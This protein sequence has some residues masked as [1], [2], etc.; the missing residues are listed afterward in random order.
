MV[1]SADGSHLVVVFIGGLKAVEHQRVEGRILA[2]AEMGA[3]AGDAHV[4][5]GGLLGN[6][7]AKGYAV[8]ERSYLHG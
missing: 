7:V 5:D 6:E 4:A 8:I 1:E 3:L 2:V